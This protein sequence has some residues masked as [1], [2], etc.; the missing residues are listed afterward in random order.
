M[1]A[2]GLGDG[3]SFGT[4]AVLVGFVVDGLNVAYVVGVGVASS[5]HDYL[6]RLVILVGH[7]LEFSS[8]FA[9]GTVGGFVAVTR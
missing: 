3:G 4:E 8:F 7:R 5:D 9:L 6:L 2:G 1:S